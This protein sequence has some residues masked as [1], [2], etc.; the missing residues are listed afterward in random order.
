M[1]YHNCI[2]FCFVGRQLPKYIGYIK[3]SQ[4]VTHWSGIQVVTHDILQIQNFLSSFLIAIYFIPKK[5]AKNLHYKLPFKCLIDYCNASQSKMYLAK[6]CQS[7]AKV[8]SNI[9]HFLSFSL[10]HTHTL[11]QLH[12]HDTHA[13]TLSNT[14]TP[15]LFYSHSHILAHLQYIAYKLLGKHHTRTHTHTHEQ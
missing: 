5:C 1:G 6:K 12:S 15:S 3:V 2:L 8:E 4:N 10:T 14:H 13:F 9:A 11:E 7:Q